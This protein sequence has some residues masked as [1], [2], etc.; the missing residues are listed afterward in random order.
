MNDYYMV[1]LTRTTI[2]IEYVYTIQQPSYQTK[3]THAYI[4]INQLNTNKWIFFLIF[5]PPLQYENPFPGGPPKAAIA[6]SSALN[7]Q[8]TGLPWITKISL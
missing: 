1:K 5:S 8:P 6:P 3:Y 2:T 7:A 4:I